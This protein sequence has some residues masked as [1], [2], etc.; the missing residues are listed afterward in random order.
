MNDAA[1]VGVDCAEVNDETL[2]AVRSTV[3]VVVAVA[4]DAG[5]VL[6]TESVAPLA[7]KRGM[8][9][10]EP[11][12]DTVMVHSSVEPETENEHP[13]AVPAFVKSSEAT[14]VTLSSNP[15]P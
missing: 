12:P 14:P 1:F 13:D 6:E 9:V 5:P 7:A 8:T 2:G 3:I 4:A 10:P 11:Q 15:S